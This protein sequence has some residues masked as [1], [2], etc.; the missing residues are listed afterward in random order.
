MKKRIPE[1]DRYAVT[2]KWSDDDQGYTAEVPDMPGCVCVMPTEAEAHGEI[3][4]LIREFLD[5]RRRRELKKLRQLV[6]A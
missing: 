5:I 2:V 3:R 6:A 1:E 4:M